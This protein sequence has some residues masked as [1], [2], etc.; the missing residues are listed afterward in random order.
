M[1]DELSPQQFDEVVECLTRLESDLRAA[2]GETDRA[3]TVDLDLPIGRLSRMDALQQQEMAKAEKALKKRRLL[4]VEAAK[5]R[6][7]DDEFGWCCSCGEAI[8]FRRLR[9]RPE[10]PFCVRCQEKLE[11]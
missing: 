1:A 2:L 6:L 5:E 9:A 7:A 10:V 4:Q 8:A 3:D 11:G